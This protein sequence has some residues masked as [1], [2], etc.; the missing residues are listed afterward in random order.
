MSYKEF[1]QN[2]LDTRGR[3][4]CGDEYHERHHIVPKCIG[5]LDI[6]SNLIDLYAKE[7]FIAHKLL[8]TENPDNDKLICAWWNMCQCKGSSQKRMIVTE[9]EYEEARLKYIQSF[10]GDKNPSARSVIRLV[11]QKIYHTVQDCRV[12]NNL[13][14][15]TIYNRLKQRRDFMYYSEWLAMSDEERLNVASIDWS[16]IEH[17]NRSN[18]AKKAGNGGS[19]KCSPSTRAK[20]GAANKKHGIAIYCPELDEYFTTIKEASEKYDINRE[21]IRLC[22]H[23]KQKHAGK[24][25]VTGEPLSWVKLENKNC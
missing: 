10:S 15:F 4:A 22:I 20:I 3:F 18:A 25:P 16:Y 1:I 19:A 7:H 5:G 8:A 11:D 2:I 24:H 12:D 6:E 21:S 23:G 17:V 9:E 14:S 13:S